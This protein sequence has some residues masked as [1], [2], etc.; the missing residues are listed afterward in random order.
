MKFNFSVVDMNISSA[1]RLKGLYF[2]KGGKPWPGLMQWRV[3][4]ADIRLQMSLTDQT[5]LIK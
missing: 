3:C 2:G 4:T 1:E 5:V